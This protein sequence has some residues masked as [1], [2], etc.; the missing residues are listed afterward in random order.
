MRFVYTPANVPEW[1]HLFN[2]VAATNGDPDSQTAFHPIRDLQYCIDSLFELYET[3]DLL[4]EFKVTIQIKIVTKK[5][6]EKQEF[7]DG[8]ELDQ[9][10]FA[11]QFL[12]PLRQL[13][14]ASDILPAQQVYHLRM[15]ILEAMAQM[16][17]AVPILV[18]KELHLLLS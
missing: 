9:T 13:S 11:E 3:L 17:D 10:D 16:I 1:I 15:M 5:T 8:Y 6:T 12:L 7:F 4:N 14:S 2:D 18:G